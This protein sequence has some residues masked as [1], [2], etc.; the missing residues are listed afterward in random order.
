MEEVTATNEEITYS[1][2]NHGL[3]ERKSAIVEEALNR[4]SDQGIALTPKNVLEEAK[5][6]YS[7]LHEFFEWDDSVAGERFRLNQARN[8]LM[9]GKFVVVIKNRA[10]NTAV[11]TGFVRSHMPIE[12]N[13][14]WLARNKVLNEA[15]ARK[16]M[17]AAKLAILLSWCHSVIDLT[18]LTSIRISIE[19]QL[20]KFKIGQ[21]L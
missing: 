1:S 18:E 12:R 5:P 7:V 4:L 3:R 20:A 2:G 15:N 14:S 9:A 17:V 6:S 11:L 16:A 21:D 10:T 19:T 8:M 13:G